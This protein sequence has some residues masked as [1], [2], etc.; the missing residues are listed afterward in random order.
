[1]C[2]LHLAFIIYLYNVTLINPLKRVNYLRYFLL[3][4]HH[5]FMY[6]FPTNVCYIFFIK[7]LFFSRLKMKIILKYCMGSQTKKKPLM[8]TWKICLRKTLCIR[9]G[10]Q[11]MKRIFC[12]YRGQVYTYSTFFLK[13]KILYY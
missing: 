13:G 8:K 2:I 12:R 10:S 9:I 7:K 6:F 4:F 1:M 3:F 11:N 5:H